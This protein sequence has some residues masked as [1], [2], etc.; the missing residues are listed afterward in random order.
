[1][2]KGIVDK[3]YFAIINNALFLCYSYNFLLMGSLVEWQ[4]RTD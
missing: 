2:R 4:K 1:M 3:A